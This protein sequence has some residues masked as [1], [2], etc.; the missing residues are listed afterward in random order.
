MVPACMM[1]AMRK[2]RA[3]LPMPAPIQIPTQ[4]NFY[5]GAHVTPAS[6]KS[7]AKTPKPTP[8]MMAPPAGK[9]GIKGD[10]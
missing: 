10:T 7:K 3:A 2:R 4:Q 5:D 1:H 9:V 8:S 6:A